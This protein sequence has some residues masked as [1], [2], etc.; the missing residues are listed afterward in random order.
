MR[1]QFRRDVRGV[2]DARDRAARAAA[3][4]ARQLAPKDTGELRAK[5]ALMYGPHGGVMLV[6][7]AAHSFFVEFGTSLMEAQPF[8]RPAVE[9]GREVMRRELR[10][11]AGRG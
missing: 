5:I 3:S 4:L 10:R 7:G 1:A 8:F 2:H 9:H 11:V 6:S